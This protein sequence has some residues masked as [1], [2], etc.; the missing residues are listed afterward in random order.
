MAEI[1][2]NIMNYE[3]KIQQERQS[4]SNRN[5]RKCGPNWGPNG[6]KMGSEGVQM[7]AWSQRSEKEVPGSPPR[8]SNRSHL[9]AQGHILMTFCDHRGDKL[10]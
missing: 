10:E 4:V 6:V 7:A 5:G 2:A 3:A 1:G 9:V 8:G